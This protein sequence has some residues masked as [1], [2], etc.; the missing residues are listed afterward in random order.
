MKK[1]LYFVH[2]VT[3]VVILSLWSWPIAAQ[4]PGRI[5]IPYADAKPIL[6]TLKPDLLPA[7][8]RT[9]TPS[10]REAAWPEWVSRRDADI[11]A[12]LAAGDEDSVVTFLLFGV[13]FTSQ[14]RYSFATAAAARAPDAVAADP[15]VQRRITDLVAGLASPGANERLQFARRV[16]E[17][18]GIDMTTAM[19]DQKVAVESGQWLLYRYNPERAAAGEN[20]LALDS[21]A[22]S[23]KVQEYLLQQTRFKMLT[24]SK[25]EEADRL[26][27]L[28]QKDVEARFRIYEY[29]A[30]RKPEAAAPAKEAEGSEQPAPA[31]AKRQRRSCTAASSAITVGS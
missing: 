14:P 15:T 24:K 25:P 30:G 1:I 23:R 2:F 12:R 8:L 22:P 13:S 18:H 20:S 27:K 9:L 17:R 6:D 31:S 4:A 3:F 5:N 11:R 7:Q 28:A 26:W 19:T 21:R 10:Q 29:M 16:I